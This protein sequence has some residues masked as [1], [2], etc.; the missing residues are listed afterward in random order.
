MSWFK[1]DDSFYDHAKVFDAPDC[2]MALWIRAGCWSARNLRDGFVPAGMPARL[3]D[4]PDTAVREL[5]NRGLW[6]RAKDGYQFHDWS[7]Y[8]PSAEKVRAT[9][10]KR[11]EAGRLGGLAKAGKQT[12]GNLLDGCQEDAKQNSAPSRPVPSSVVSVVSQLSHRYARDLDD[13][14]F[15]KRLIG[16]NQ[17]KCGTVLAAADVR[18]MAERILERGNGSVKD[19]QAYVIRA[20]ENESDPVARWLPER[21]GGDAGSPPSM[22][23]H[24]F[25]PDASGT[26]CT[27]CRLP[28]SN[29]HH[30]EA[31]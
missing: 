6:R 22:D 18:T 16:L 26:T 8:Q 10:A 25:E 19:P 3:C 13:D 24:K 30:L 27:E 23:L 7:E 14:D 2:A 9:R 5:L 29:R 11:A 20:V 1:V 12:A 31:S 4:D 17:R 28:K 15:Q 21:L